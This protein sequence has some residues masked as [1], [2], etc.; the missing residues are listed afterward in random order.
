MDEAHRYDAIRYVSLNPVRARLVK[1]ARDWEWSSVAAHLAGRDDAVVRVAP[2]LERV[3][4]FARFLEE[5]TDEDTTYAAL[6][7]AE[8][9][10]RPI[11]DPDW[12]AAL[13]ARTGRPLAPARRGPKPRKGI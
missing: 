11:G 2:V 13:E 6:R 4:D 3:G 9:I 8:T 12:L 7:R 1:R 10:G 5:P